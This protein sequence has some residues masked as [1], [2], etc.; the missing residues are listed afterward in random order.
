MKDLQRGSI[1]LHKQIWWQEWDRLQELQ[2]NAKQDLY[3]FVSGSRFLQTASNALDT[4]CKTDDPDT[5]PRTTPPLTLLSSWRQTISTVKSPEVIQKYFAE[6]K[7]K[8]DQALKQSADEVRSLEETISKKSCIRGANDVVTGLWVR[9]SGTNGGMVPLEEIHCVDLELKE[10]ILQDYRQILHFYSEKLREFDAETRLMSQRITSLGWTPEDEFRMKKLKLEFAVSGGGGGSI[11]NA[12]Q[13]KRL[14][15]ERAKLEFGTDDTERIM[16]FYAL[17]DAIHLQK[18][19]RKALIKSK[20][21]RIQ[22]FIKLAQRSVEL[23]NDH[24]AHNEERMKDQE[25]QLQR[26]SERHDQIKTWREQKKRSLQHESQIR[27]MEQLA[28]QHAERER[29][30][31]EEEIRRRAKD[32]VLSFK[33]EAN[34]RLRR[35]MEMEK[36]TKEKEL[37]ILKAQKKING[38]RI[39]FRKQ[40]HQSKL[41]QQVEQNKAKLR[42]QTAKQ[43]RLERLRAQVLVDVEADWSRILK[44]TQTRKFASQAEKDCLPPLVGYATETILADPRTR[45]TTAM[46]AAGLKFDSYAKALY[47]SFPRPQ[48]VH[49]EST[50]QLSMEPTA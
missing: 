43:A 46:A 16:A 42:E 19:H 9:G 35:A 1:G 50:V 7:Q 11:L 12:N 22:E 24:H 14:L 10:S 33:E 41:L 29:Q 27:E 17:M 32:R 15:I 39:N 28:R 49:M 21:Q 20:Q 2:S 23:C 45:F 18:M 44:E 40:L 31:K 48:P 13:N 5:I 26:A 25:I 38:E 34:E 4:E 47:K 30:V 36:K 8:L 6:Q 3:G 37:E